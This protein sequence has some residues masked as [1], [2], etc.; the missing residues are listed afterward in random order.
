MKLKTGVKS[1]LKTPA[2]FL[3]FFSIKSYFSC[4]MQTET[5]VNG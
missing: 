2:R 1:N 4:F 5:K 3:L